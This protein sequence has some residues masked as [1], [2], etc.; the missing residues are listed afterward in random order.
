ML[1]GPACF[2]GENINGMVNAHPVAPVR[3]G[4]WNMQQADKSWL[5]IIL[6][7]EMAP[8][9][10]RAPRLCRENSPLCSFSA[11]GHS[12]TTC[13]WFAGGQRETGTFP[14]STWSPQA[15]WP[16]HIHGWVRLRW[17]LTIPGSHFKWFV[18]NRSPQLPTGVR[19][20]CSGALSSAGALLT[21]FLFQSTR[22]DNLTQKIKVNRFQTGPLCH[23][24][25]T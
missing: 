21:K 15:V 23:S 24:S 2:A 14:R 12:H 5:W 11:Q 8:M 1:S 25:L 17:I 4:I 19:T 20:N 18:L 22:K 9:I 16:S 6:E 13:F 3:E 10:S 7:L